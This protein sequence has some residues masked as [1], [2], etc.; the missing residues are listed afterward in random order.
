MI[1]IKRLKAEML[2][3]DIKVPQLAQ[4]IG[5]DKVTFYRKLSGKSEFTISEIYNIIEVLKIPDEK[6]VSIFFTK[7]VS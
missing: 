6:I 3:E 4:T 1:D 7:K 2:M 5:I